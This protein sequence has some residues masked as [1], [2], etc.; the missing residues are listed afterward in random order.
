MTSSGSGASSR[1]CSRA[2]ALRPVSAAWPGEPSSPVP[3]C[4]VLPR[5]AGVFAGGPQDVAAEGSSPSAGLLP[6]ANGTCLLGRSAAF[7]PSITTQKGF[8]LAKASGVTACYA[9]FVLQLSCS[10]WGAR[11]SSES[12]RG[13]KHRGK[14]G[15]MGSAHLPSWQCPGRKRSTKVWDFPGHV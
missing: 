12:S 11:A 4:C 13:R 9:D 14:R 10:A 8:P 3:G 15:G 5:R 1:R 6:G 7:T 2:R